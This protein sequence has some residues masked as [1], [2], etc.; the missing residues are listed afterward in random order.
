MVMALAS[1][2]MFALALSI[3]LDQAATMDC[4]LVRMLLIPW[5]ALVTEHVTVP[6]IAAAL[7]ILLM[8]NVK[9]PSAVDFQLII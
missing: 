9:P 1:C 5:Y 4:A 6:T 8:L 2:Q 3:L 7:P